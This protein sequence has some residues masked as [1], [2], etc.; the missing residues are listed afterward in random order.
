[1]LLSIPMAIEFRNQYRAKEHEFVS[2]FFLVVTV[3]LFGLGMFAAN[4]FVWLVLLRRSLIVCDKWRFNS[5]RSIAAP[6]SP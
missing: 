3:V 4:V 6:S 2:M 1:M 5:H